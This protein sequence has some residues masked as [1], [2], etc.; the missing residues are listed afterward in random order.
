MFLGAQVVNQIAFIVMLVNGTIV[1]YIKQ[2]LVTSAD[3]EWLTRVMKNCKYIVSS[4]KKNSN[5]KRASCTVHMMT[6]VWVAET[7]AVLDDVA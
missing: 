7:E 5:T 2:N 3:E 1:T 6:R 4:K